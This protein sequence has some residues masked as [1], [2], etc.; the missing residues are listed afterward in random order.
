LAGA[1]AVMTTSS[2][3]RKGPQYTATLVDGLKSW[4][5]EHGFQSVDDMKGLLSHAKVSDPLPLERANYIRVLES[6][7]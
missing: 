5:D 1:D 4:M 3:L 7:R 6:Y 2:L